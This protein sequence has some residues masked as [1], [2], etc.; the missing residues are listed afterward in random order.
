M[1]W[2]ELGEYGLEIELNNYKRNLSQWIEYAEEWTIT[3]L[4]E[5]D[6]FFLEVL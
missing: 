5:N 2:Y 1:I 4:E 3:K 6:P